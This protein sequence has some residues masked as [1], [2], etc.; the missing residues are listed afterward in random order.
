MHDSESFRQQEKFKR[1]TGNL[2]SNNLSP[3]LGSAHILLGKRP[4]DTCRAAVRK[5][6]TLLFSIPMTR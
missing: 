1:Y 4:K 2:F 6:E 3:K 5:K